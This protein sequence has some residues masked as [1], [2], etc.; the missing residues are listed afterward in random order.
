METATL[1]FDKSPFQTYHHRSPP[2]PSTTTANEN[3]TAQ[4]L[5]PLPTQSKGGYCWAEVPTA[6]A[7]LV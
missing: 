1:C 3:E 4:R 2:L 5:A 7:T 6:C